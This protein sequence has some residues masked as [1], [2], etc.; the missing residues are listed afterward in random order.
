MQGPRTTMH[1]SSSQNANGAPGLEELIREV[2][3]WNRWGPNDQLGT[4]NTITPEK[5]LQA[6][7]LVRAG[8]SISLAI[9]LSGSGPMDS[10]S[11]LARFNPIR[12]MLLTGTDLG[13]Y[14]PEFSYA[15][16]IVTM[17][18]QCATHWD[19]LAHVFHR[20]VMYNGHPASLVS[21]AG[22][23]VNGIEH[24]SGRLVSRGIL[25]DIPRF[26][27]V[28]RVEPEEPIFSDELEA[29]ALSH[30]IEVGAGDVLLVRTGSMAK[31][32]QRG[33]WTGYVLENSPGLS[34][35]TVR[36]LRGRDVAA[37]ASDTRAVEVLPSDL[38][39]TPVAFHILA[40]VHMGL[41]LG[42][43]FNLEELAEACAE[44]QRWEFLLVAQPL[45]FANAV[46]GPVNPSAIL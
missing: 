24:L 39:G 3:N 25:L 41:L 21:S 1:L 30:G 11:R 33:D 38:I 26:R 7:K 29:I 27:G 37:V 22:A 44:L 19:A 8:R 14:P 43:M 13:V 20:G 12:S 28:D 2:S 31:Y 15:D 16:D 10:R 32:L 42:E 36:W 9:P 35:T 4:I 5:V 40:I 17:P 23:Q 6:S 46:G 18:L 45:P 34:H